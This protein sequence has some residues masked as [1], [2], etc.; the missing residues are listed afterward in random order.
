MKY[1]SQEQA[2]YKEIVQYFTKKEI[3][4][5]SNVSLDAVYKRLMFYSLAHLGIRRSIRSKQ[6]DFPE[7]KTLE[8]FL[9]T[10]FSKPKRDIKEENVKYSIPKKMCTEELIYNCIEVNKNNPLSMLWVKKKK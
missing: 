5:Y 4:E 1:N 8:G 3:A 10:K 9:N 7:L 6:K 2:A